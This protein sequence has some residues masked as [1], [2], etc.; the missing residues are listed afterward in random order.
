LPYPFLVLAT[1]NPIEL[2]GTFPLPEAQIDRFLMRVALGYPEQEEEREILRR[3]RADDPLEQIEPVLST[4]EIR[5]ASDIC[6]QV[7]VHPVIEEYILELTRSSRSD[8]AI[9]LGVSPR[10]SLALYHTCQALAALRGRNYVL[11]DDVK[12]QVAHVLA[13]RLILSS[14]ARLH[15]RTSEEVLEDLVE[16][17]TV[18]VEETWSGETTH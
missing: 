9:A 11:P 6:R 18:P 2:E 13:H 7:Y 17:V 10:G 14:D 3:F 12:Y 5:Q 8:A 1:Q 15:G 16:R 4:E